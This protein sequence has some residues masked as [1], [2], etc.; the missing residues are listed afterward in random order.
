M[1]L[2]LYDCDVTLLLLSDLQQCLD[3]TERCTVPQAYPVMLLK[4]EQDTVSYLFKA[5][6]E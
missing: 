1:I 6:K 2:S 4:Y 3:G 5:G